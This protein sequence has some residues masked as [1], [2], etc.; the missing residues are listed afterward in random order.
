MNELTRYNL[1]CWNVGGMFHSVLTGGGVLEKCFFLNFFAQSPPLT[2][3]MKKKIGVQSCAAEKVPENQQ[4][5]TKIEKK[6]GKKRKKKNFFCA[7]YSP[8]NVC[9]LVKI[10]ASKVNF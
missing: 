10:S 6:V 9:D 4:K 3:R 2:P 8:G 5:V 1:L 7:P